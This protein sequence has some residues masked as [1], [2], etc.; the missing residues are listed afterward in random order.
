MKLAEASNTAKVIAASTILLASDA[1]TASQVAPGAAA[2]CKQFLSGSKADRWLARSAAQPFTRWIW[3][4]LEKLTLPGIMAHYWHRKRWIEACCRRAIDEGF[5]R[6]VILGAGFDTLGV[7]LAHEFPH[8]DVIEIDH[9]ATQAAKRQGLARCM[10]TPANLRLVPLD[11]SKAPLPASLLDHSG[12]SFFII[13]GVL[14]YLS[15]TDIDRLFNT[16]RQLSTGQIRIVFSFM[17]QWAEGS[18]G[19]RPRSWLIERWL[20]WRNEP[21]T[22]AIAPEAMEDFLAKRRFRLVK[23]VLTREFSSLP[24]I[25]VSEAL[26]GENLVVCRP[27]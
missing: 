25:G 19:F 5:E 16:L 4:T 9:P 10:T 24:M 21:F 2:L 15:Q 26:D 11:L 13:E 8:I 18:S 20:T 3:R 7:R 12:A 1:R 14:M 6:V 27:A 22:W 23:M 17:T